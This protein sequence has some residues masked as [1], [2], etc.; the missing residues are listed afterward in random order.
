MNP[1]KSRLKHKG[2]PE[3][4]G[5]E[6]GFESSPLSMWRRGGGEKIWQDNLNFQA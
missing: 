3:T 1:L 4:A 5:E 6:T 2:I